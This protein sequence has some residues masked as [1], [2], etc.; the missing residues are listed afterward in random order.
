MGGFI[1]AQYVLCNELI[2]ASKRGLV[3]NV[4]QTCFA[5]G[6]MAFSLTAYYVRTWRS[7]TWIISLVGVPLFFL[8][9]LVP[10]SPRWYL[11][12]GR[13]KEAQEVLKTI[14]RKNGKAMSAV[15]QEGRRYY[16]TN[17]RFI[18]KSATY[19]EQISTWVGFVACIFPFLTFHVCTFPYL[20]I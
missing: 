11:A 12:Q 5:L 13:P 18:R 17:R 16:Y 10:E 2:G 1:I 15:G 9:C 3:G 6:I 8:E 19:G 20:L 14:A 4:L 7:L